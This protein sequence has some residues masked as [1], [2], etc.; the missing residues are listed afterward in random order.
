MDL[1]TR[2]LEEVDISD[3]EVQEV[4]LVIAVDYGTTFTGMRVFP[5]PNSC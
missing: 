3:Q 2:E 4:R 5:E 1:L